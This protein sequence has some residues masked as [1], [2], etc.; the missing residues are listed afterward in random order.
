[1]AV[2]QINVQELA[3]GSVATSKIANLAVDTAKIANSAVDNSK[4]ANN[5]VDVNKIADGAVAT[6]KIAD[7]A[8]TTA[9]IPDGAVTSVKLAG[10]VLASVLAGKTAGRWVQAPEQ[11]N[12]NATTL[13]VK[14]LL[15]FDTTAGVDPEGTTKGKGALLEAAGG[16]E[17]NTTTGKVGG[18]AKARSSKVMIVDAN[19]DAIVDANGREVWGVISCSARTTGGSYTLRFFSGE[20]GDASSAAYN[21]NQ[22]F[23]FAYGQIFD[24]SDMPQWDD[25]SVAMIDKEAAQ[26]APGQITT[27]LIADNAVTNAKINAGAVDNG[28]LADGSVGTSKLQNNAVDGSKLAQNSVTQG[29]TDVSVTDILADLGLDST[30]PSTTVGRGTVLMNGDELKVLQLASPGMAVRTTTPGKAYN[31]AGRGGNVATEANIGIATAPS[32]NSRHDIVVLNAGAYVV[33]QGTAQASPVDPALNP[34][35]VPLARIVVGTNVTQIVTANITDLRQRKSIMGT[36]LIDGTVQNAAIAAAAVDASK[37]TAPLA[38]RVGGACDA[39]FVGL[40]DGT[41]N[42]DLGHSDVDG[43][44]AGL[45]VYKNGI[46]MEIGGGNDYT[47]SD[48]G[49]AGGVDRIVFASAPANGSKILCRYRRTSLVG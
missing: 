49:G 36:K 4:L 41:V 14:T 32:S 12:P 15:G 19:G 45:Q 39:Q 33:R 27:T 43:T 37:L 47:F 23:V 7:N 3:D 42:F 25:A 40:S 38:A 10:G 44:A 5:A 13:N 22:G 18:S 2:T 20:F 26:L 6:A 29:H 48:N 24:L 31:N 28:K 16:A 30:A 46:I 34:G 35:D 1:M 21:M 17:F 8:V 9:K 11:A